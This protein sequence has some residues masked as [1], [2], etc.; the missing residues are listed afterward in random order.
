MSKMGAFDLGTTNTL[1]GTYDETG[2]M[3]VF[4]TNSVGSHLTPSVVM[5]RAKDDVMVGEIPYE[6]APIYPESTV[7]HVKRMMGLEKVALSCQGEDYSPQQISAFILTSVK[8]DAERQSGEEIKEAVITVPAYFRE[9]QRRATIE[10]GELAGIKVADILHEPSAAIYGVAAKRNL[11]GE[12]VLV[13]DLGGGTLDLL[14]AEVQKNEINELVIGGDNHL[15]GNDWNERNNQYIKDKFFAGKCIPV[16]VEQELII[17]AEMAKKDLSEVEQT[18]FS[19][20]MPDEKIEITETREEFDNCTV[21]LLEKTRARI[22]DV[23]AN[24]AKVQKNRGEISKVILAGGATRM[25][26]I[27]RLL[28][29]EFP[30]VEVIAEDVDKIVTIGAAMYAY[31]LEK[32]KQAKIRSCFRDEPNDTQKKLNR[33]TSRSYGVAAYVNNVRKIC[34]V[35]LQ[36]TPVTQD[37]V[38]EEFYTRREN[39]TEVDI[40]IYETTSDKTSVEM[41]EGTLIGQCKLQLRGNLPIGSPIL[42]KMGLHENGTLHVRGFENSG[43]TEVETYIHTETLSNSAEEFALQKQQ[44]EDM[45]MVVS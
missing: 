10:A 40:D 28:A 7:Q 33:I 23:K 14:V 27:T 38:E 34:N 24:Y 9:N 32:Q 29:E 37:D 16:D 41:K 3:V 44:I 5:I 8:K 13:F 18:R 20:T 45:L 2:N 43:K 21:E 22:H 4:S 6:C 19:V 12:I 1:Y 31:D 39:Q 11:D 25:P 30:N 42:I 17:K 15:G 35:I 26:Q 36:N